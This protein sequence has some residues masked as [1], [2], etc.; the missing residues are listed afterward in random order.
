[1][2][3]TLDIFSGRPNPSWTMG[4]EDQK[5]LARRLMGLPRAT[6]VVGSDGLGYRGFVITSQAGPGSLPA[7]VRV[8]EGVVTIKEDAGFSTFHDTNH[9]EK[10]L[11]EQARQHRLESLL[12]SVPGL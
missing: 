9:L 5:E 8:F 12:A 10:W 4:P 7:E 1:M 2:T 11:V 6:G 3:V